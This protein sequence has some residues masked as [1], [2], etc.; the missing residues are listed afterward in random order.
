M[1][2]SE[3][4]RALRRIALQ[5]RLAFA[6]ADKKAADLALCRAIE[7]LDVLQDADLLL[8]FMPM[9]GEPDLTSLWRVAERR[10]IPVALP[11]CE[12]GVM[13]FHTVTAREALIPDQFG[14]PAPRPDAPLA[15]PTRRSLCLLPGLAATK[16]GDRLGYGGGFYDRFLPGFPGVT[17]FP[18]YDF[19]LF[20]SLP[21]EKTDI[22]PD[23]LLLHQAQ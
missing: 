9:R 20:D 21:V 23:I 2:L 12:G 8:L 14:I 1:Q 22:K 18:L 10:G 4:K 11:R 17:L 3:Q 13:T 5:R 7:E 16:E 15:A 19:L 6:A